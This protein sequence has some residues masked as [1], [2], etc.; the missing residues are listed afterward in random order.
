MTWPTL[1]GNWYYFGKSG[2]NNW[3]RLYTDAESEI[4]LMNT[5]WKKYVFYYYL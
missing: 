4:S 1:G 3:D 2:S 5:I